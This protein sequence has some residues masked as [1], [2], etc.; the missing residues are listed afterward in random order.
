MLVAKVWLRLEANGRRFPVG[1]EI[2]W[3]THEYDKITV[4]QITGNSRIGAS[5]GKTILSLMVGQSHACVK[6]VEHN[7]INHS[8]YEFVFIEIE[9]N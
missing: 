6:G 1:Q 8:E 2:S 4:Q 9:L 7:V 3:H 5:S